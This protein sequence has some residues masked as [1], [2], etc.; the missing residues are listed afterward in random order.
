MPFD[1]RPTLHQALRRVNRAFDALS[2]AHQARTVNPILR[3]TGQPVYLDHEATFSALQNRYPPRAGYGYDACSTWRRGVTRA[4]WLIENC[5]LT[6]P[7]KAVLEVA[8]GDGMVGLALA[9]FGH[10]VTLNDRVDWRDPRAAALPF[11]LGDVCRRLALES[12]SFDLV[13]SYN[14]FEHL[15]DPPAAL[16]EL[17]RLCRPGGLIY[18]SFG[19]LY[20]SPWGLHAYRTLHMPFPQFLFSPAF[21]ARKLVQLGIR[22]LGQAQSALQPLNRWRLARFDSLWSRSGCERLHLRHTAAS[23]MHLDLIRRYPHAFAGRGLTFADVS[24][25]A[26]S[27]LLK[28]PSAPSP[29]VAGG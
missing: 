6:A 23:P 17:L 12:E 10:R 13:C 9:G 4:G 2:L 14:A 5:A 29:E 28:K 20:A 11:V 27:V 7:G 24:T 16:A 21:L 25:Q 19:P 26:V 3:R 22:D 8:C 18:L 1:T 15:A